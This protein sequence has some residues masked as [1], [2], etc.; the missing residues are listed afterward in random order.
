MNEIRFAHPPEAEN[1]G[2][3]EWWNIGNQKRQFKHESRQDGPTFQYSII[4][5]HIFTA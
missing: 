2:T 4:P 3:M 1:D 5:W